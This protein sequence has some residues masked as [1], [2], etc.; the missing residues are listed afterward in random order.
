MTRDKNIL[1]SRLREKKFLL[2]KN[3]VEPL[4]FLTK[5]RVAKKLGIID[6]LKLNYICIMETI[7]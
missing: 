5:Q 4:H 3:Q 1:H 6:F 2:T 7:R